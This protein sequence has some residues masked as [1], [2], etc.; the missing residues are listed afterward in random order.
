MRISRHVPCFRKL[1]TDSSCLELECKPHVEQLCAAQMSRA[2]L[3]LAQASDWLNKGLRQTLINTFL[4]YFVR[5]AIRPMKSLNMA[6]LNPLKNSCFAM[7]QLRSL[8]MALSQERG[9]G[10]A[11]QSTAHT[12]GGRIRMNRRRSEP[13]RIRRRLQGET[14]LRRMTISSSDSHWS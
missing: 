5:S 10:S 11:A 14:S 3:H 13:L 8:L 2:A 7:N 4:E 6:G 1:C 12:S 9:A